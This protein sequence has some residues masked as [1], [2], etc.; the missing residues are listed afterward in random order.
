MITVLVRHFGYTI[1]PDEAILK[2]GRRDCGLAL[3]MGNATVQRLLALK[4]NPLLH[5]LFTNRH[6][7][8]QSLDWDILST[9]R[10]L[11][12]PLSST[13]SLLHP[14]THH[15]TNFSI[16]TPDVSI[17]PSLGGTSSVVG[18]ALCILRH[19]ERTNYCILRG[20]YGALPA[21]AVEVS[22]RMRI[23]PA[24]QLRESSRLRLVIQH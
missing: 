6:C 11:K 19:R 5:N 12:Q 13:T 7:V 21:I 1:L 20:I 10:V 3:T 15:P 18:S 24:A 4:G 14:L 9:L 22:S 8:I 2:G 16:P 17:S 23:S